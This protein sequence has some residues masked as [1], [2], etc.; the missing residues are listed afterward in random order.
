MERRPLATTNALE[1][2]SPKRWPT[3]NA[4]DVFTHAKCET[5]E[6]VIGI[7]AVIRIHHLTFFD[8]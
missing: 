3:R 6:N 5:A 4:R 8:Y 2:L 7:N 1:K